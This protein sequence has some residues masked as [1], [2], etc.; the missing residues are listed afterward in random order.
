MS[1]QNRRDVATRKV[2][3]FHKLAATLVKAGLHPNH[4]SVASAVF[5]TIAGLG[6][7]FAGTCEPMWPYIVL[8]IVGVQLRLICN[9]IDGL[10]AVE[11]G[12]KTPTGEIYNDLPDRISDAAILIGIGYG[13]TS[14]TEYGPALG[15][16]AAVGAIMTAYVRVLGAS[17]NA[18]HFFTGPMAKQHRMFL[19]T[20]GGIIWLIEKS[21]NGTAMSMTAILLIILIGTV[22]TCGRRL[23]LIGKK[24]NP[25]A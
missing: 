3:F 12:L 15:W 9:L 22:L 14:Y 17:M 2:P 24:L 5:G 13:L 23:Y 21:I 8:G 4:V 6:F 10:M 19:V 20:L 18:G 11:G 16:A 25:G 1:D 7:Y